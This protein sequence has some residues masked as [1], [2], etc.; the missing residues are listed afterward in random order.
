MVH[1]WPILWV[2]AGGFIGSVLRYALAG[3]VHRL[4]PFAAFPYGTLAVNVT[5]CLAIG[6][7]GGIS[8]GRQTVGPD[9]RLFL[10]I[11]VLGG[12]TT[13]STFGHETLALAR[14]GEYLKASANVLLQVTVGLTAVWLGYGAGRLR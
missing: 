14:D 2:G 1:I 9:L 4:I 3:L 6:I 13:F 7:L 11:G 5:G 12:F 8:D 10:L